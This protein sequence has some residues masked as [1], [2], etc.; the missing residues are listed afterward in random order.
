M[1]VAGRLDAQQRGAEPVNRARL[2]RDHRAN[3]DPNRLHVS[4]PRS[5][6]TEGEQRRHTDMLPPGAKSFHADRIQRR[7]GRVVSRRWV[8]PRRA[9]LS[10]MDHPAREPIEA[11][12]GTSL[13][14]R[15]GGR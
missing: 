3:R 10:T 15:R 6:R 1:R 5:P 13:T 8:G 11:A 7:A 4:A 9:T 12:F 14:G 2:A